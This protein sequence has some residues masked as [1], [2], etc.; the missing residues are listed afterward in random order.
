M[1]SGG[2]ITRA[3]GLDRSGFLELPGSE[4]SLDPQQDAVPAAVV[5]ERFTFE[6]EKVRAVAAR[7]A[8]K[9][10]AWGFGFCS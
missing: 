7:A 1:F 5:A 4:P 2:V 8:L 10:V 3:D 9:D 6:L